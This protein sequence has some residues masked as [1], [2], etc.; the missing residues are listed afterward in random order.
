M[1]CPTDEAMI[2]DLLAPRASADHCAGCRARREQLSRTLG[3]TGAVLQT[4]D[5][6]HHAGWERLMTAIQTGPTPARPSTLRRFI[7]DRRTWFGAATAAAICITIIGALSPTGIVLGQVAKQMEA[8]KTW[9]YDL[10]VLSGDLK[11][12]VEKENMKFKVVEAS[13]GSSRLDYPD[14]S[15]TY[16]H[17]ARGRGIDIQHTRKIAVEYPRPTVKDGSVLHHEKLL[18]HI[19]TLHDST[20]KPDAYV[21]L[22]GVRCGRF[23]LYF[24]G[25]H[26]D[27]KPCDYRIWIDLQS[28]RPVKIETYTGDEDRSG[29][30]GRITN[31]AWNVDTRN[32]FDLSV[33]DGYHYFKLSE[34]PTAN[35]FD[36]T[37]EQIREA[38]RV[39]AVLA[40][41]YPDTFKDVDLTRFSGNIDQFEVSQKVMSGLVL[42]QN[43]LANKN[44][45]CHY[46]FLVKPG[47]ADKILFD[48]KQPDGKVRVI[49]GDLKMKLL[50]AEEYELL[51]K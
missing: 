7:M 30:I 34:P 23:D 32:K 43:I 45:F 33:P 50:T 26:L 28:K 21:E 14:G 47:D 5:A 19:R 35:P 4:L 22:G 13:D 10:A 41:C 20:R 40:T 6:T 39:H 11:D 37:A 46:E 12:F 9:S 8:A 18:S 42:L 17:D 31:I 48:W 25:A 29:T 2:A 24:D 3:E 38:L 16:I 27:Q 1:N 44:S 15:R 49:Y 36:Q 51:P